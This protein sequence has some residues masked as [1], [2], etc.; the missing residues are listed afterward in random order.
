[1]NFPPAFPAWLAAAIGVAVVLSIAIYTILLRQ[2][3]MGGGKVSAREFG[4]PDLFLGSF[5]AIWFG[6]AITQGFRAAPHALTNR[7]VVHGA[8]LF[9][10]IMSGIAG[11]LRY[12]GLQLRSQFGFT[13]IS[14]PKALAIALALLLATYPTIALVG[15]LTEQA[16][17]EKA[18]RQEVVSFFLDA[19]Q[20]SN[21]F[22]LVL[23]LF[24]GVIVAPVAEE[25]LF[26]G[27][28]YGVMKRYCGTLSAM[29][30]SSAL[31]AAIHLNLSSLP[32]LFVLALCFVI[33][34]ETTGSIL[35]NMSMHALFNATMFLVMLNLPPSLR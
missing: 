3:L 35:V 11:F 15:K 14:A 8:V 23:T 4:L 34:Y 21:R 19:A 25:F 5:F 2:V 30:L 12:R 33:A 24:L 28:L 26:R 10:V 17:G 6:V 31:F 9:V 27:Y 32:S 18:Q 1:M 13:R 7:D 22:S 20:S 29:V 16:L